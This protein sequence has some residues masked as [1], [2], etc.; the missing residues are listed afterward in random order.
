MGIPDLSS[1]TMSPL[2]QDHHQ[3]ILQRASGLFK[4]CGIKAVTMDDVSK[5]LSISKKTLY[6]YFKNKGDLV[7]QSVAY[8][9]LQRHNEALAI[10]AKH[11]N[12]VDELIALNENI[13]Q[14]LEKH[15]PM[16]LF[17]LEKYHNKT[18][19]WLDQKRK[20]VTLEIYSSN[21]KRGIDQG[22][23]H[24]QVTM[25]DVSYLRYS[26]ITVLMEDDDLTNDIPLRNTLLSS[27][28]DLYIRAIATPQGLS[29]YREHSQ[30]IIAN[31]ETIK[32]LS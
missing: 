4:R 13:I 26:Q 9:F 16:M 28:L 25:R 3:S 27:S 24:G 7:Q 18:Y 8:V 11:D 12:A 17:A 10:Q 22:L 31:P 30:S 19:Q 23:Y 2:T 15:T 32:P 21:L 29:Y 14:T 6:Q 20:S 5:D 1:P